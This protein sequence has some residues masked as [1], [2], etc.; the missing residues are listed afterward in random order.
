MYTNEKCI[1]KAPYTRASWKK[2]QPNNC[3]PQNAALLKS[4]CYT[5]FISTV[6]AFTIKRC[7]SSK[8]QFLKHAWV[9]LE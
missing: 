4:K 3:P 6:L 8:K 1:N 9:H 7:L 5:Q 2:I